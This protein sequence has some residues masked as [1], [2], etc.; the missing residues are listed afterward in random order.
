M[1]NGE[2]ISSITQP[3]NWLKIPAIR[4]YDPREQE[5]PHKYTILSNI[6]PSFPDS[7]N[8]NGKMNWFDIRE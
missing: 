2:S 1:R 5:K 3:N 8:Q 6:L 7:A 4:Y